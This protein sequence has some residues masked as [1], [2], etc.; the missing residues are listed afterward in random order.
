MD[1]MPLPCPTTLCKSSFFSPAVSV[2]PLR[3]QITSSQE[4]LLPAVSFISLLTLL[5]LTLCSARK[6]ILP[7]Q[8]VDDLEYPSDTSVGNECV[9]DDDECHRI[10]IPFFIT[11]AC[12]ESRANNIRITFAS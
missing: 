9:D 12:R 2:S 8:R 4:D 1:R 11:A 6:T 7:D 5:T 3:I 10:E